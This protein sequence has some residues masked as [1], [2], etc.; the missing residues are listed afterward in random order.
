MDFKRLT[1]RAQVE[2]LIDWHNQNLEVPLGIDTETTSIDPRKA[3]LIDV[4][5][6]GYSAESAVIFSGV[7][8]SSL[9]R[10][11]PGK[12]LVAHHAPYDIHV[13]SRHGVDLLSRSWTDTL[14][15]GHLVDENRDSYSLDSY[16]QELWQDDYKKQFWS[17]YK[18]YKEAL[19]QDQTEYACKDVVYTLRLYNKLREDLW[20]QDI[21][22]SLVSLVHRLQ[23]HLCKTQIEGLAVDLN[24]LL[25]KGVDVKRR[26]D[27]L[28]PEMRAEVD[29][30]CQIWEMQEYEKELAKRKTDK[31]K[32]G[33]SRPTFSFDSSKQLQH[34][35]YD[36]LRLP[37]QRNEKTKSVSAD[38]AALENLKES[39]PLIPKLLE[40][41]GHQKVYTAYI[42]G[43]QS[44]LDGGRI[45]PHFGV[46]G[47]GSDSGGS[48][49]GTK[50]GRISHSN[51]NL[52]QLPSSGGIRGVYIPDPGYV[53]LSADYSQLEVNIEA[54]LTG[55]PNLAKIFTE[56]LSKHD[57]TAQGLGLDRGTAKTLNFAMQYWCTH[58]KVAKLLGC[59]EARAKQVWNEYWR[60]YAGCKALKAE[61]DRKIDAGEHLTTLFGRKRRFEIRKRS[62]W[63]K[64]YRQGYN[65][66]IQGTGADC[67]NEAYVD[68]NDGFIERGWGRVLFTV[69]DELLAMVRSEVAEEAEEFML[70]TMVNVGHKIGLK[71]PL[72]AVGSGPM[73]RWLD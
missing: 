57:I 24:Y 29:I 5:L 31:G 13:L 69:H 36:G 65:F 50:T 54:N 10:L 56:G 18:T 47:R 4:Q 26:I 71:I 64:A 9:L 37:V 17:K 14:I 61:T 43:T 32:A 34:L 40:Y 35:L 59:S 46:A 6:S 60:T 49:G 66:E 48:D 27:Q 41:R 73:N 45:Y 7:F 44:R 30:Y 19:E 16:V 28:L 22:T 53:F 33:V 38:E 72:K 8:A 51:P 52:G 2:H 68:T 63:D 23:R 58:F 21:P 25:A 70:K 39:H 3:E 42:E 20:V 1:D 15:L 11:H 55:D 12:E 67:T 62:P